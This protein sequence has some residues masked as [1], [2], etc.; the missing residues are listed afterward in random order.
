MGDLDNKPK[1]QI[2]AERDSARMT[3][4]RE[5]E[6]LEADNARLRDRVRVLEEALRGCVEAW[7]DSWDCSSDPGHETMNGPITNARQALEGGGFYHE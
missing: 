4:A 3:L 5:V 1:A 7:D 2:L 6:A